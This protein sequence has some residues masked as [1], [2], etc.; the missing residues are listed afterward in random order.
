MARDLTREIFLKIKGQDDATPI[1]NQKAYLFRMAANLATDYL[2]VEQRRAEI[3]ME[4]ND[5][6][7]EQVEYRHPERLLMPVRNWPVWKK[8]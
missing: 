6:L 8:P 7:R 2:R 1:H 4:A 3:L 5:L